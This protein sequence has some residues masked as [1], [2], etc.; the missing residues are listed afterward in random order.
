MLQSLKRR[1]G[2]LAGALALLILLA[3]LLAASDSQ[4][5][6]QHHETSCFICLLAGGT[7]ELTPVS[8]A[9]PAAIFMLLGICLTAFFKVEH[10]D[11]LL[12]L[13]RAPPLS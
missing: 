2:W 11:L 3:G 7:F 13:G 5:R 6:A 4:H 1:A 9:M 8:L 10:C 12:P